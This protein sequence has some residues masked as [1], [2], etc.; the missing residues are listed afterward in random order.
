MVSWS[1]DM[2]S[3]VSVSLWRYIELAQRDGLA[4]QTAY[5]GYRKAGGRIGARRFR[6]LW[7][8]A[9]LNPFVWNRSS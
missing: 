1:K 9:K 8:L 6:T 7:R 5:G 4:Q 2:S 3:G